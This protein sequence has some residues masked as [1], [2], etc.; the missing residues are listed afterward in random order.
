MNRRVIGIEKSPR[1]IGISCTIS[2]K[3]GLTLTLWIH[4]SFAG[5]SVSLHCVR[6]GPDP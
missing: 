4:P 5:P 2:V 1:K 3:L 6:A